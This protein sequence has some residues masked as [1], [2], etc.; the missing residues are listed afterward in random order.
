MNDDARSH[1]DEIPV[2]VVFPVLEHLHVPFFCFCLRKDL[3]RAVTSDWRE[4]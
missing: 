1:E 2:S 3:F 4:R